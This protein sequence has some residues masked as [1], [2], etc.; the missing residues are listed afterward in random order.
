MEVLVDSSVW[1]DYFK[2]GQNTEHLDELIDHNFIVINQVILSELI[3]VLNLRKQVKLI[4]LLLK[5]KTLEI[6][7]DWQEIMKTQYSL[8][9][10]G[11]NGVGVPDLIIEQNARQNDVAIY[12]LDKHFQKLSQMTGITLLQ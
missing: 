10:I 11:M 4:N 8:L 5:L 12:S 3:P 6:N 9:K 2:S 1:I 7:I